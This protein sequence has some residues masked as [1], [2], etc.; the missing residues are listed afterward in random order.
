MG[1]SRT[2]EHFRRGITLIEVMIATVVISIA[3]TGALSY[4]YHGAKQV[5][6]A[7]DY[8]GAVRIGRYL[9]EDWKANGGVAS[10][11]S[12][13]S[14]AYSPVDLNISGLGSSV[15]FL[16]IGPGLY[17]S[18]FNNMPMEIRLSQG[19]YSTTGYPRLIPIKANV[20]WNRGSVE[21]VTYARSD[22]S[23]G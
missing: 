9:L 21:L 11:G 8:V 15:S 23:G 5:R 2:K 4:H 3:A 7:R 22:Q 1:V 17:K 6:L 18:T 16:H 14:G 12:G 20:T 13:A 19:S 10:Y